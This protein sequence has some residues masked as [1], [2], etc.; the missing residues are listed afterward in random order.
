MFRD[1][2]G[3]HLAGQEDFRIVVNSTFVISRSLLMMFSII[4]YILLCNTNLNHY[5]NFYD[6]SF[7]SRMN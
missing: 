6:Y 4:L 2:Q 7:Y 5:I 1:C 3:V